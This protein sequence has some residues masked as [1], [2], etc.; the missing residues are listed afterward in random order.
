MKRSTVEVTNPMRQVSGDRAIA[1]KCIS[2]QA[3]APISGV[4]ELVDR[5]DVILLDIWG[6]LTNGSQAYDGVLEAVHKLKK[7]GK[8]IVV[9][10]NSSKRKEATV[11]ML[12]KLGFNTDDFAKIITSGEVSYTM[13][14][15][16]LF[17]PGLDRK[18]TVLGSGDEDVEYCRAAGWDV[19]SIDDASLVLARGTFT[20]VT[21]T[22]QEDKRT[23]A[24][25]YEE[26]L[27][28]TLQQA[29]KRKLPM[30]I[31]NPDKVRPDAER[32]PMPGKIGDMYK[33]LL[34]DSD[35]GLIRRIGKPFPDVYQAAGFSKDDRLCMVGDALET[36]VTGGIRNGVDTLWVLC[37]GIYSDDINE[38][39]MLVDAKSVLD[40]FNAEEG[41]YADEFAPLQ[42]TMVASHF[43]W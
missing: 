29:A 13:L 26:A 41:T 17:M 31:S 28:K 9:L 36:D 19:C 24:K 12:T 8:T 38:E 34:D 37:D 20:V 3:L 32:P 14:K 39:T 2:L 21:D 22:I 18:V 23:D 1:G 42:P 30:L 5:Y 25:A 40:K 43:R 10:S 11:R 16:P 27:D 6:V 7:A 4:S 15:D 35:H 33:T